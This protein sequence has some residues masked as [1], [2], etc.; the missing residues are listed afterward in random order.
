MWVGP[1]AEHKVINDRGKGS[2]WKKN[3]NYCELTALYKIWKNLPEEQTHIG[4]SHYRRQLLLKK[5]ANEGKLHS[6]YSNTSILPIETISSNNIFCLNSDDFKI[7]DGMDIVL[8]CEENIHGSIEKHFI[9]NHG[10]ESWNLM[11]GILEENGEKETV[12][13]LL[14]KQNHKSRWGNLF[15]LRKCFFKDFCEWLFP[16]LEKME[17]K[18]KQIQGFREERIYGFI[19]E[20]MFSSY[21]NRLIS[22]RKNLNIIQRPTLIIDFE[23]PELWNRINGLAPKEKFWIWG[24]GSFGEKFLNGLRLIGQEQNVL[25]FID[26][27]PSVQFQTFLSFEVHPP[28]YYFNNEN[29]SN[30]NFIVVASS[31]WAEISKKLKFE[32]RREFLDYFCI[33]GFQ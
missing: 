22:K 9:Q 6:F 11:I 30:S 24:A 19:A 8:S 20:R 23:N 17:T 25:G 12:D 1:T 14:N 16:L 5:I 31:K 32:G 26:S 27:N 7:L 3:L 29:N 15:L 21:F 18:A 10:F 2:I 28:E 4:F 33:K 13:W